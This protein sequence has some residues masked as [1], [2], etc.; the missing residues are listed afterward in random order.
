AGCKK[1]KEAGF[2]EAQIGTVDALTGKTELE[3]VC[4]AGC[5]LKSIEPFR[6][7]DKLRF[8]YLG[9]NDL[10]DLSP[11]AGCN[12]EE[13]YIDNN[14]LSGHTDTFKGITLNGFVCMEGNGFNEAEIQNII[15]NMDGD[16]TVYY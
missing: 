12:I 4:L 8:V 10:T 16:F 6:D 13:F 9:R 5:G 1:L 3:M 7:C 11:L 2:N 15:D 14:Q